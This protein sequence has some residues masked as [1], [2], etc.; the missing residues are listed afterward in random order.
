M[1]NTYKLLIM[2]Q[3]TGNVIENIREVFFNICS[4]RIGI[5]TVFDY[6]FDVFLDYQMSDICN[7]MYGRIP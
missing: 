2:Q 1:I 6:E 5:S 7:I 4:I 3:K